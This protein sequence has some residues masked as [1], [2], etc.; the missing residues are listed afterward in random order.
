MKRYATEEQ[1]MAFAAEHA[2]HRIGNEDGCGIYAPNFY[3][4]LRIHTNTLR[5]MQRKKLIGVEG[6]GR[7]QYMKV[8]TSGHA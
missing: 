8:R 5:S 2:D 4:G 6:E 1:V 7:F 3:P